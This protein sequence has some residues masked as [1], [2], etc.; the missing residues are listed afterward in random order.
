MAMIYSTKSLT[1]GLLCLALMTGIAQA[2]NMV[3]FNQVIKSLS[4]TRNTAKRVGINT[5]AVRRDIEARIKAEG[6]ENAQ[7]QFAVLKE[8]KKLPQLIVQIQFNLDS[9]VIRPE[10]WVT[11]GRIAD[12]LHHPLLA[13]NRFLIV[14]HTDAQGKR[15]YNLELS[16]RRAL[17]VTGMLIS[18]FRVNPKRLIAMGLGEEQLFNK[19]KPNSGVNRRVEL[20]NLG[21]L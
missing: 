21:P 16:Q 7:G 11:V 9:D 10:S 17:S 8:L 14:G 18:T 6:G 1:T 19:S 20:L 5:E 2:Q 4:P 3:S 13:G 15:L 12:A